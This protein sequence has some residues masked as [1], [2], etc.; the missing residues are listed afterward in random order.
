MDEVRVGVIPAA[1]LGNR[2]AGLGMRRRA[3]KA[4]LPLVGR[5]LIEYPL[6][7]IVQLGARTVHVVVGPEAEADLVRA[8]LGDGSD[9]NLDLRFIVQNERKGLAHAIS[10]AEGHLQQPFAVV[11]G[12]DITI[13]PSLR[14][15]VDLFLETGATA[16]QY[17][18]AET[19]LAAIQHSCQVRF[20]HDS[21]IIDI[22][23][24][25][26]APT[27]GYRGVGVYLFRPSIF[28]Q[29][30]S[31][32]VSSRSGQVEL[33]D[34]IKSVAKQGKAYTH[35]IEGLNINLNTPSDFLEAC[36]ELLRRLRA[37]EGSL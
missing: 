5:L 30:H 13:S 29:I 32:L 23:E 15:G 18:I 12:D 10:L 4:T 37:E 34:T 20:G 33:T 31:T 27:Q 2:L 1:G 26:S 36:D 3:P 14:P 25:P 7:T 24:K 11:L 16:L 17:S 9:W 6:H 35:P 19:R 21:R 8:F 22:I 28:G